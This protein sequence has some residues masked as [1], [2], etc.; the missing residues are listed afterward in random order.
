MRGLAT[1]RK[2]PQRWYGPPSQGMLR[3][4]MKTVIVA[5]AALLAGLFLGG[6]GPRAE[7]RRTKQEL[8]EAKAAAKEGVQSAL[9]LAL[10]MGGLMAARD[11]ARSVP[12]F[13]IPD[14]GAS[15]ET[16]SATAEEGGRRRRRLFGDGGV[17]TFGAV[18]AAA[19]VRA[20]QFR[21][22]FMQ[23]ANLSAE[24]QAT[25][26]QVINQMNQDFTKV[27]DEMAESLRGKGTKVRPR[28]MADMGVKL[29][30][31]YRR[32]DD[33]FTAGLDDAGK[34]AQA[35]T[36]FD[37]LTQVDVGAFQR[38]A[39]TVESLGVSTPGKGGTP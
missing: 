30:E 5:A 21:E 29:L 1:N 24:R 19:D 27:A 31:V 28:D 2:P 11:R 33:A 38:L 15:D 9:P 26:D 18:K 12:R 14:A 17:E 13:V 7:L 37:V 39:E 35:K 8:A 22:A 16:A 4:V 32:A 23:E 34:A 36:E 20:A 6:I 10:G 3:P 25:V